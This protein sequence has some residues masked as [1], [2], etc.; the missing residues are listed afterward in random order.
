VRHE[1]RFAIV[2]VADEG[3]GMSADFVR[4]HLFKPF[5][6][7]KASGMGI[8]VYE[9]WQYLTA[10]GGSIE[11]DTAEGRGTR[12][13]VAIPLAEARSAPPEPRLD[14]AAA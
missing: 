1:D 13:R 8:G 4:E 12:V 10:L 2:V 6:T 7:T 3:P 11:F 14:E 5:Q 9:S